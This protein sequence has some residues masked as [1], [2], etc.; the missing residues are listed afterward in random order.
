MR[1]ARICT[2]TLLLR[3][4]KASQ[5]FSFPL[6]SDI[7]PENLISD[8]LSVFDYKQETEV[9]IK[10]ENTGDII[11]NLAAIEKIDSDLL[12]GSFLV[13]F[14]E[15]DLKTKDFYEKANALSQQ[16]KVMSHFGMIKDTLK[17]LS[18]YHST[19]FKHQIL[20]LAVTD[21]IN[22]NPTPMAEGI[23]SW[24]T[25]IEPQIVISAMIEVASTQFSDRY[26]WTDLSAENAVQATLGIEDQSLVLF[27]T[28]LAQIILY[29]S[30]YRGIVVPIINPFRP[31]KLS[32]LMIRSFI[33]VVCSKCT[34]E[35]SSL[36]L[37]GIFRDTWLFESFV[38]T[39]SFRRFIE[40]DPVSTIFPFLYVRGIV[41]CILGSRIDPEDGIAIIQQIAEPDL[42]LSAKLAKAIVKPLLGAVFNA[43]LSREHAKQHDSTLST[44]TVNKYFEHVLKV[45]DKFIKPYPHAQ[46]ATILTLQKEFTKRH[47]FPAGLFS[48]FF[49]TFYRT[50]K[51]SI[52]VI[53]AWIKNSS[54]RSPG[55]ES[56][57]LEITTF[58]ITEIPNSIQDILPM[59][60]PQKEEEEESN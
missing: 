60:E 57:L 59:P 44:Y 10:D 12:N 11:A 29:H 32:T 21:I 40:A 54:T 20:V 36:I 37:S 27:S 33:S 55:K 17:K 18:Q 26:F 51:I 9:L 19:I 58:I 48:Q 25:A 5:P 42:V 38:D 14:R 39:E 16:N 3:V 49:S 8:I 35:D 50:K 45:M 34:V 7:T 24:I 47:F 28:V 6:R 23:F 1:P 2:G 15:V 46:Y 43:I 52:P 53:N 13:S 41:Y 22:K 31:S 56:A 4:T 30:Q